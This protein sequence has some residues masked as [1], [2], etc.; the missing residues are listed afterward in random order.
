MCIHED[1]DISLLHSK[2]DF[3]CRKACFWK[4]LKWNISQRYVRCKSYPKSYE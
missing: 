2:G 4:N 3:H 1:L